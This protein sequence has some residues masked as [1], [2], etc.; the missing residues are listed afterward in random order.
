[1]PHVRYQCD[2]CGSPSLVPFFCR[3][4]SVICHLFVSSCV[5]S[6]STEQTTGADTAVGGPATSNDSMIHR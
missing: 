5:R 6:L 1:M 4:S 2:T 3:C